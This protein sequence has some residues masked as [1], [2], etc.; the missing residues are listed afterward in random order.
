MNLNKYLNGEGN[1]GFE[2]GN[3]QKYKNFEENSDRIEKSSNP[4]RKFKER[5]HK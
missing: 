3:Q 5:L 2:N 4:T 1:P